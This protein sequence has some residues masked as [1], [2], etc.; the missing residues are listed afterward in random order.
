M[1]YINTIRGG[2]AARV[3]IQLAER[4]SKAGYKTIIVTSFVEET[5]YIVPSGV[6]R[7][8]LEQEQ[9]NQSKLQRNITRTQK[10]R[11]LCKLYKPLALISFMA[12]PNFR[13]LFATIGL[14]VKN[15]IS[16]RNDPS[17]EYAGSLNHYLAKYMLP[18]ADGCVFQTEQAKAWFPKRTQKKSKIIT[19]MLTESFFHLNRFYGGDIVTIGRLSAQK[20]HKLLIRAFS[21]ICAK[22]PGV[23]LR[24]YGSGELEPELRKEIQDLKMEGVVML[25]G[26]TENVES[27]LSEASLFVL[28]S[29]YEGMPN[30][31]MEALA[32]GLPSISTD[33][34]VGGPATLIKSGENGL[35]VPVG[36]KKIMAEAIDLLLSKPYYAQTL[37]KNAQAAAAAS[38]HP[39]VVFEEWKA[40][41]E[42][43]ISRVE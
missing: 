10:L 21:L 43:I 37:G 36:D 14:P 18:L 40:Y 41:L 16:V 6:E 20:N 35:L 26:L 9:I 17:R 22:H 8:S 32:A 29:D 5:E 28:P 33:C 31:L 23:L 34:P 42:N 7:M 25:M 30:A 39:S 24:I 3:M 27:I 38:Y 15:I 19:N 2:G 1:F 4:F 13:A 11:K 12:E